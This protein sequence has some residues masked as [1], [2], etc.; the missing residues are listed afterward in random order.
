MQVF[1]SKPSHAIQTTPGKDPRWPPRLS[2]WVPLR[3]WLTMA[4]L[5]LF[6]SKS[7]AWDAFH[8]HPHGPLFSFPCPAFKT[9]TP[10]PIALP[11]HRLHYSPYHLAPSNICHQLH[12]LFFYLLSLKYMP[13]EKREFCLV[14][15]LYLQHVKQC[16][17]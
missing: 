2:F 15:L 4:S 14:C 6:I 3:L 16:R 7:L 13:D 12:C 9:K 8:P 11:I 10:S 5:V 17:I 1:C